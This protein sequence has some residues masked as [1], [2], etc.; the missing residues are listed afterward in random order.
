MSDR[1]TPE[2]TLL[3]A[4]V[5]LPALI[6]AAAG[7]ADAA[8]AV[9]PGR[10]AGFGLFFHGAALGAAVGLAAL[11]PV[12][13]FMGLFHRPARPG[14]R[15][16]VMLALLAVS[17]VA[18]L[19]ARTLYKR[20]PWGPLDGAI[21]AAGLLG[22]LVVAGIAGG[23]GSTLPRRREARLVSG[24]ARAV[25]PALLLAIPGAVRLLA[26]TGP[27]PA[28]AAAN[29]DGPNLLLLSVDTLRPDR[30]GT[31]G[32]PRARTPWI[33]RLARR[34][35]TYPTCVAPSPWTLPS[36]G[37]LLTGTHPGEHRV[38]EELSGLAAS[39]PTLAE[40]CRASGRRTAA[41]VSNPWLATGSLARG[42]DTFDVAE[43]LECLDPVRGT[44]MARLLSKTLLR[45]FRL[46][47]AD[48]LSDQGAAWVARGEG[49]WFL[50][51][52]YFDPHL[53]NW[54]G[55]PWDRLIGPAPI[56]VG[57]ALTVEEIRAGEW[58]GGDAG[59]EEIERLYDGEVA[60]TDRGVGRLWRALAESGRL[61]RTAIVF[62]GDHGEELW[63]HAGYGHGHAMWDE[64]VRVPL[65]VRPPGGT[66]GRVVGA[67]VR[68]I[69]VAPTA[70][71]RA[72]VPAP[73]D[74][75]FSGHVLGPGGSAR[76]ADGAPDSSPPPAYGEAVLYGPEQ[77]FLRTDRWKL[78]YRPGAPDSLLLF[79][80]AADPGERHEVA[81]S[82]PVRVDSLRA[83]LGRWMEAVGSAGALAARDLPD[84]LDPSV[85]EQLKALGYID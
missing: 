59:R 47:R 19:L 40:A 26:A 52:H 84:D 22:I 55:F 35:I 72:G 62:T 25:V 54:P 85:R 65:L 7:L 77:K 34:A 15:L 79:D 6:G 61:E 75:P 43:R 51:V 30:L 76:P 3:L 9:G 18:L 5:G 56:H 23:L 71:A 31:L 44:R 83:E 49:A 27:P 70:L 50:W 33:D 16:G 21:A 12:S 78:V 48:R 41:F 80:L 69:D 29:A 37:T 57:S 68:L 53:P 13:L 28:Q 63:D 81:A 32:D 11:L 45:G 17:P 36:L 73:A 46:D 14:A 2:R 24:L 74:R 20:I 4:L 58:P 10:V 1:R 64:V 8:L 82:E 60:L 67:P 42:F 39:V 66:V 38:L